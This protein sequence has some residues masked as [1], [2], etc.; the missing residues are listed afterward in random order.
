MRWL[1]DSLDNR[2]TAFT[3]EQRRRLGLDGLLPPRVESL[4]EQVARVLEAVRAKAR[5]L[6]KYHLLSALQRENETVFHGIVLDHLEE[7]AL[8]TVCADV[9]PELCLPVTIDVGT[10]NERLLRDPFYLGSREPRLT[11]EDYDALLRDMRPSHRH[12]TCAPKSDSSSLGGQGVC[13]TIV[14]EKVHGDSRGQGRHAFAGI[15]SAAFNA[16]ESA[17]ATDVGECAPKS[18]GSIGMGGR[19][20]FALRNRR[21]LVLKGGYR[22]RLMRSSSIRQVENDL[23]R[24]GGHLTRIDGSQ[25]PLIPDGQYVTWYVADLHHFHLDD[26]IHNTT[27][28]YHGLIRPSRGDRGED[29]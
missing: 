3:D 7:L 28:L 25:P 23:G 18:G 2:G 16:G 12:R 26:V 24:P 11:G 5:P 6:D 22:I 8:Y 4:A 14:L 13:R 10:N 19:D 29:R 21:G 1:Y 9:P 17:G 20:A 15:G 27:L